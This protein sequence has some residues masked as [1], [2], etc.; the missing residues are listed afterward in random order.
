MTTQ[1]VIIS[2]GET[3]TQQTY[4]GVS[5]LVRNAD[6]Y[7][8]AT[9]MGSRDHRDV[10]DFL[11]GKRFVQICTIWSSEA[12]G[13]QQAKYVLPTVGHINEV[14]GTYVH[15]KLVHFVA[16][17]VDLKY[18]FTVQ[19]I[20]DS[21]NKQLHS[22]MN[23][24]DLPDEPVV[25]KRLLD[26]ATVEL[27]AKDAEI[28]ELKED[29][30]RLENEFY[31]LVLEN[32]KN[33][34]GRKKMERKVVRLEEQQFDKDVRTNFCSRRI[35]ILRD[36]KKCYYLSSDDKGNYQGLELVRE[37]L[38]VSGI[39]VR[40]DV[41]T[42][43]GRQFNRRIDIVPKFSEAELPEVTTYIEELNPKEI[44]IHV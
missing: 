37:C 33:E 28:E 29:Y 41:R 23:N 8:N 1:K 30:E 24:N 7:I 16:E 27:K 22:I 35:K 15:A 5:I 26:S 19:R 13:V 25:A 12:Q 43:M 20:M 31:D 4:N 32:V 34:Q 14:K 17:W 42:W 6:G 3:F 36:E 11:G 21:V 9:K 38:F 39:N 44:T 2:G 40:L 10:H 18:A